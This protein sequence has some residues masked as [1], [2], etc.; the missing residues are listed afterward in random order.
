MRDFGACCQHG[1]HCVDWWKSVKPFR[2]SVKS[3]SHYKCIN[4]GHLSTG[5]IFTLI[6]KRFAFVV[7]LIN[8]SIGHTSEN[9]VSNSACV[10]EIILFSSFDQIRQQ[11]NRNEMDGLGSEVGNKMRVSH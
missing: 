3:R 11:N 4:I 8:I 6:C 1:R 9:S 5:V 7:K 10:N 2:H